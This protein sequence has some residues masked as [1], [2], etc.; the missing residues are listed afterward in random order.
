MNTLSN[1]RAPGRLI[2]KI[3]HSD[4][5]K[6]SGIEPIHLSQCVPLWSSGSNQKLIWSNSAKFT[7][8]KDWSGNWEKSV[9]STSPTF[10]VYS[11]GSFLIFILSLH[12]S[13]TTS[14][15]IIVIYVH[16]SHDSYLAFILNYLIPL[17]LISLV[18]VFWKNS[19]SDI[20]LSI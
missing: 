15:I 17:L 4:W 11:E 20:Y 8:V 2:R 9:L 3:L 12:Y 5:P 18:E 7:A 16:N 13:P 19:H 10:T 14:F 1:T 6:S